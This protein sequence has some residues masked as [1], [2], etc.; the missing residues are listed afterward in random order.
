FQAEV[1]RFFDTEYPRDIIAKVKSGQR[2]E[3]EDHVRSQQALQAR[4]W[5][6]APWPAEFGGPGWTPL[7]RY[8]FD[9]ELE[10]A[11]AP[12]LLPMAVIY[13]GPVVYTFGTPEQQRRWLPDI[14]DSRAMWAQGYSEP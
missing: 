1:R 11:G 8:L 2:L 3:R 14:L 7:Q 5:L 9:A 4:G 13:V 6:A 10:R 12:N